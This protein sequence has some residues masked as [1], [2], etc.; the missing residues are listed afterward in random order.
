MGFL[1]HQEEQDDVPESETGHH[2]GAGDCDG[3]IDFGDEIF[4]LRVHRIH[5][6]EQGVFLYDEV[7]ENGEYKYVPYFICEDCWLEDQQGLL[8]TIQGE[9]PVAAKNHLC[10]C[11]ACQ[12]SILSGELVGLLEYGD[13][14]QDPR[15]PVGSEGPSVQFFPQ[16][17]A[18]YLCTRCLN[19]LNVEVREYWERDIRHGNECPNGLDERCWRSGECQHVCRHERAYQWA[20]ENTT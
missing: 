8:D 18:F 16:G 11:D 12:S 4:L 6:N 15:E 20:S 13:L 10:Q 17:E 7:D 2:C 19:V 3:G 14:F 9:N 5:Q 1:R